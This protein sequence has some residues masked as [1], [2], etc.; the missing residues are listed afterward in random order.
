MTDRTRPT[1]RFTARHATEPGTRWGVTA[2]IVRCTDDG[3][4]STTQVP[5]FEI[6]PRVQ[7]CVTSQQAHR[8]AYAIVADIL[9]VSRE[10]LVTPGSRIQASITVAP[11][12]RVLA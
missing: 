3:W 7:G 1:I 4:E 6:N 2:Q 9:G 12:A 8:V 10:S 11:V 5:Y